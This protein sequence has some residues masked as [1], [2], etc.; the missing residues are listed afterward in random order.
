[1]QPDTEPFA[2]NWSYLKVELNWLER[3]LMLA[4]ARQRKETKE[5]E[6]IVQ[7][8]ADRV[9][10]HWW[11]GLVVLEEGTA[12]DEGSQRKTLNRDSLV[13]HKGNYQQQLEA[14]IEASQKQGIVLGLPALRQ[15]LGLTVLEKNLLLMGLAPE[16]N[17]RYARIYS[18]LQGSDLPSDPRLDL[19][20]ALQSPGPFRGYT[21]LP[22][23]D[24]AL[25]ILCRNDAEWR[26]SRDCLTHS[27]L[28][29]LGFLEL[30]SQGEETLLTRRIKLQTSLVDYL[31]AERLQPD[32]LEQLVQNHSG[33]TAQNYSGHP[34]YF[35]SCCE[36]PEASPSKASKLSSSLLQS[37]QSVLAEMSQQWLS[38]RGQILLLIG[39]SES[40]DHILARTIAQSLDCP[41]NIAN[42]A[43]IPAAEYEAFLQEIQELQPQGM[44]L[45]SA[46]L[47][48]GRSS[49]L[50]PAQISQFLAQRK[51]TT[52][53]TLLT[54][55]FRLPIQF[56]WR[57]GIDQVLEL[58][59]VS[60]SRRRRGEARS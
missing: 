2:D 26:S 27:C 18:Y 34:Q 59:A 41:L 28:L 39:Q 30:V 49:P 42:L 47:W 25:R 13:P 19:W 23:V 16:V 14:R 24:L 48:L 37:A 11:K 4:V 32:R 20:K 15:R 3:V 51:Q 53:I 22:T 56:Y 6:R 57:Q 50:T 60:R 10:S 36:I 40:A 17:R 38:E 12:Y 43:L 21:E 9:T 54:M 33:K 46:Q 35:Q 44:L 45:Q 55:P 5:V 1:M 52:G 58:P 8:R 29:Q 31:L 7:S